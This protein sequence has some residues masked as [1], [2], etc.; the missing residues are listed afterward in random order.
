MNTQHK[1][2]AR[3]TQTI[4]P[5]YGLGFLV[6]LK[7]VP[8]REIEG[9]LV[10]DVRFN[11]VEEC[12]A[13]VVPL[14]PAP[15]SG[16]EFRFVR[17]HLGWTQEDVAGKLAVTRQAVIGWERQGDASTRMEP[18][19]EKVFRVLA[20]DA[21]GIAPELFKRAFDLIFSERH[22]PAE[23]FEL[24]AGRMLD[25]RRFLQSQLRAA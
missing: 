15:L 23:P 6:N 19:T 18:S 7:D 8:L 24:P 21:Q 12:M 2:S 20:L 1:K 11:K 10:P 16:N 5:Y 9:Q 4:Y 25:R 14:K 22:G 3:K 13:L 17:R